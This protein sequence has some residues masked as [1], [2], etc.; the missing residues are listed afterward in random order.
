MKIR[1]ASYAVRIV[2]R[3][4]GDAAILYRRGLDAKHRDRLTRLAAIAPLALLAG[5]PLLRD[6]IRGSEGADATLT[7]GPFHP[8]T[9][10][11]GAR[12][13]CYALV[14][15]GLKDPDRL[16]RAARHLMAADGAEA[17][18]WLGMM[19]NSR[20]VRAVRAL[21]ILVEAVQ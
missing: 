8:L 18:W 13:G 6:A 4:E 10:E 12:V 19:L 3:R 5:A 21:R 2:R 17:A 1:E 11:W 9:P 14:A 16:A 20:G 15:Q 7:P